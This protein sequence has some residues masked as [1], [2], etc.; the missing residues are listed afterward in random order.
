MY[1]GGPLIEDKPAV[2]VKADVLDYA[3]GSS[4]GCA[5]ASDRDT[6]GVLDQGMCSK[7]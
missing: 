1:S 7:G 4:P 5:M 3:E 6:T 2:R